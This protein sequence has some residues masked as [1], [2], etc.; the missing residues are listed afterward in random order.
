MILDKD[1]FGIWSFVAKRAFKATF[2][3]PE[4][5]SDVDFTQ[6]FGEENVGIYMHIPSARQVRDTT[7]VLNEKHILQKAKERLP[8]KLYKFQREEHS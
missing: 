4:S 3:R 2:R 8:S 5:L 1:S 6:N 7:S